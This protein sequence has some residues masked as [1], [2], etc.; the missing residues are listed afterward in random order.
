MITVTYSGFYNVFTINSNKTITKIYTQSLLNIVPNGIYCAEIDE[1][2][3]YLIIGSNAI[4][5]SKVNSN[6]VFIWRVLN[7]EPWLKH[8]PILEEH[9]RNKVVFQLKL[10]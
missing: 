9:I 2:N 10:F 8:V 4:T 6:G 1:K 3:Q 7:G 5:S